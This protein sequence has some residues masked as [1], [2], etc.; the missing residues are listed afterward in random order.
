MMGRPKKLDA[1]GSSSIGELQNLQR[2]V[3]A[4]LAAE[5]QFPGYEQERWV[6]AQGYAEAPWEELV[7]LWRLQNRRLAAVMRRIPAEKLTT[8][9]RIGSGDPVTLGWIVED[10]LRHVEH[11]LE[12]IA[13]SRP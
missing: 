10:Y 13:K 2:F 5:L 6:A 11:H 1:V 8:P 7:E 9:C 3:R 12:Q 4:Q